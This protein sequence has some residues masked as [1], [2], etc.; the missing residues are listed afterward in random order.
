MT[1]STSQPYLVFN[2]LCYSV[3]S[4]RVL[5]KAV[6]AS[7]FSGDRIA[8]VGKNGIGKSTLLRLLARQL[9]PTSG[10]VSSSASTVYVPQLSLL[11]PTIRPQSVLDFLSATAD[12]W[13]EIEHVL[14]TTFDT[15]LDLSTAMESLSG[16][17]LMQLFLAIALWRSPDVLLLDEPTNHLDYV[18]LEQLCQALFQFKGALVV[19]SHKPFFLD[20][21]VNTTWALTASGLRVYGGN[22]SLYREQTEREQEA[23]RRSHETARKE[24]KRTK[25]SAQMEQKRA[26]Q[27]RRQGRQKSLNGGLPR[28]VAGGLKR[29]AQNVAGAEK[30]KHDAAVLA[31]EKKVAETKVRSHKATSIQLTVKSKKQ[32]NLVNIQGAALL[33]G[34]RQLLTD[35]SLQIGSGERIVIAGPNGSGKSSLIKAI[36]G[37]A[38]S[39]VDLRNGEQQI[40]KMKTVYLDQQYALVDRSL[41]ILE[42][43]HR[44]NPSLNYQLLRQQLGHFLF[45]NDDVHKLAA[46]LSGGE[47]AR[48]AIALITISELDLLVLDEPTNNLDLATVDQMVDALNHYKGALCVVSHDL[49]FVSRIDIRKS[50]R[51]TDGEL[52][53]MDYLAEV[54]R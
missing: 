7:L 28:I 19:V 29:G 3:A 11:A 50:F 22:Y 30:L 8:L 52:K 17:E 32:R 49:D 25:A 24:L 48:C 20:K 45:F 46:V 51:L 42:N 13:W 54:Q 10:S 9:P 38:D 33:V 1:Q 4:E 26:A 18:A 47:L 14:K 35:V 41:S 12:S 23:A 44:A 37:I 53:E 16:G 27:S 15:V 36:L 40:A 31:A 21:V 39:S 2:N 34:G 5:F 6:S 43:M